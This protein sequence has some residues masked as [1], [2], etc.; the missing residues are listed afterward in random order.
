MS[1]AAI[2]K[3]LSALLRPIAALA[4]SLFVIF[5]LPVL[6]F[7][8][9]FRRGTLSSILCALGVIAYFAFLFWFLRKNEKDLDDAKDVSGVSS[10]SIASDTWNRFT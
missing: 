4:T 6:G 10:D 3:Q 9:F 8:W 2:A 5:G 1:W 7:V